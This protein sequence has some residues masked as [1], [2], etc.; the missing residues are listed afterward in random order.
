MMITEPTRLVDLLTDIDMDL[1]FYLLALLGMGSCSGDGI[2]AICRRFDL[3]CS[4]RFRSISDK[5]PSTTSPA[6]VIDVTFL[7]F[8][9]SPSPHSLSSFSLL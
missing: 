3:I 4:G 1:L 5:Q 6:A 2:F 8:H 7:S 9:S